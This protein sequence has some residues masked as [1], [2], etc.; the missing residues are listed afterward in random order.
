MPQCHSCGDIFP[1]WKAL[2]DH[3]AT[4]KTG[5]RKGKKWAAKI[6]MVNS[7]SAKARYGKKNF[8]RTPLTE[9]QKEA[10]ELSQ[11]E[12]SGEIEVVTTVCPKCKHQAHQVLPVEFTQNN[13]A[14]RIKALLPVFCEG[15]HG[16]H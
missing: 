14:W 8:E 15:C 13:H 2:A 16:V 9:E 5:H 11:R 3:I 12:L 1:D 10:K 6:R 4:S 7:L